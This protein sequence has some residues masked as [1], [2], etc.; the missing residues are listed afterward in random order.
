MLNLLQSRPVT[1]SYSVD[2]SVEAGLFEKDLP[3][4]PATVDINRII[5]TSVHDPYNRIVIKLDLDGWRH[6]DIAEYAGVPTG[7]IARVIRHQMPRVMSAI[8]RSAAL[9]M[10]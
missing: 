5:D 1:E 2:R 6:E 4:Q 8:R 10:G 9:V 3:D 7:E